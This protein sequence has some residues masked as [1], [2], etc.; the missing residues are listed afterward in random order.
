M[1]QEMSE[2]NWREDIQSGV[3]EMH[4]AKS[5]FVCLLFFYYYL[6]NHCPYL[7][8]AQDISWQDY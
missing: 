7:Q 4:E 1:Y 3:R 5:L 8:S 6:K 2:L